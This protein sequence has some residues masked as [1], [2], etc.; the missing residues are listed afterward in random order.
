MFSARVSP[1]PPVFT[2]QP[3]A[4][5]LKAEL[6]PLSTSQYI[7]LNNVATQT[8][9][10]PFTALGAASGV[11]GIV[12][13]GLQLATTLQTYIE[14][15]LEADERLRAIAHDISAT[16][17]ALQQLEI[18]IEIDQKSKRKVFSSAGLKGVTDTADQCDAVFRKVVGLLGGA[19]KV[20]ARNE[21]GSG[22]GGGEKGIDAWRLG[23]MERLKWPWLEPRIERCRQELERLL[24]KLLVMLQ[25]VTLG[26][27]QM[28]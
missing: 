14:T 27:H 23:R 4:W 12:S 19:T 7:P 11:V 24:L 22:G 26:R 15:S 20:E 18:I 3:R 2:G 9:M 25:V 21:D 6:K 16:S 8:P 5:W 28:M 10:D 17:S 13:F 1:S